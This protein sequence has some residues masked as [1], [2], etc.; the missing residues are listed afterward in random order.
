MFT[1]VKIYEDGCSVCETMSRFDKSVFEGY[2]NCRVIDLPF[3][4]LQD[5]EGD[6]FKQRVYR[7]VETYAVSPTYEIEFP[8]YIFLDDRG[9]YAGYLQGAL[10]LRDFREG[11]KSILENTSPE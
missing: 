8:T 5:Y 1:V 3:E 6:A 7:L 2:P 9:K 4:V 11:V 10:D